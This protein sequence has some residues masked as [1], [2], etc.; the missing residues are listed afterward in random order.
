MNLWIVKNIYIYVY[1][2]LSLRDV[3]S[4]IHVGQNIT[5]GLNDSTCNNPATVT[6]LYNNEFIANWSKPNVTYPKTVRKSVNLTNP[7]SMT[8]YNAAC[9]DSGNYTLRVC[10][11]SESSRCTFTFLVDVTNFSNNA[12]PSFAALPCAQA[13]VILL[14]ISIF[15]N[16]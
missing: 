16:I 7:C 14:L 2:L 11:R 6:W 3:I 4:K 5:F 9:N 13:S 12:V 15:L 8:I 1:V 10:E